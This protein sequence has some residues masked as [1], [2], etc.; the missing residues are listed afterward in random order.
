MK[1]WSLGKDAWN[2]WVVKNPDASISF[3]QADF[4]TIANNEIDFKHFTFPSGELSFID[5]I[6]SDKIVN[7]SFSKINCKKILLSRN[8][9]RGQLLFVSCIFDS[10]DI[11]LSY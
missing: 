8:D 2:R 3:E 4:S 6:F 9:F 7:F 11:D 5:A 1:L 10:T